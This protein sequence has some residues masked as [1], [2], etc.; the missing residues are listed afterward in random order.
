MQSPVGNDVPVARSDS[1]AIV[2]MW[3]GMLGEAGI[4][5]RIAPTEVGATSLVPGL[6]RWEIRVAPIDAARARDVLPPEVAQP[7]R[8]VRTTKDER[9]DRVVQMLIVAALFVLSVLAI[10]LLSRALL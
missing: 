6:S 9:R 2:E 4:G 8:P 5:C 1:M 10:V 3:A 7:A